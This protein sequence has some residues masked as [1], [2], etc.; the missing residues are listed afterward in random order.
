MTVELWA[1]VI[2]A[3]ASIVVSVLGSLALQ[4]FGRVSKDL[5]KLITSVD[6]L[7]VKIAVVIAK[8]DNHDS[9]LTKLEEKK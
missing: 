6:E 1:Q 9:R 8:V 5:D 7:N 3:G 2:L 4:V